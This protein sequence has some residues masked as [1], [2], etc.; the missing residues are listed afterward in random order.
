MNNLIHL[1]FALSLFFISNWFGKNSTRFGYYQ[2]SFMENE[3]KPIFNI[4]YRSFTPVIFISALSILLNKLDATNLL[5]NIYLVTVYY[6]AI[7]FFFIIITRREKLTSWKKQIMISSIS[8]GLSYLVYINFITKKNFPLPTEQEI[9]TALW[10]AVIGYIYKTLD[11]ISIQ[12][13]S[14]IRKKCYIESMHK[15][16]SFKYENTIEQLIK[17]KDEIFIEKEKALIYS[18]LIYENFNRHKLIR[19]LEKLFFWTGKVKTSG[20]MQV[21]SKKYLSDMDSLKIG[22]AILIDKYEQVFKKTFEDTEN[23]QHSFHVARRESI[24]S[25]NPDRKYIDEVEAIHTELKGIY[26]KSSDL[27]E[28]E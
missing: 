27:Y 3:E 7:R 23:E 13:S 25:Y 1:L 12:S 28:G 22:A 26:P 10:F 19:I 20:I 14:D 2:L 4:L 5:D 21:S 24:K 16:F 17:N 11:N 15:G 9:A 6:I 8:I 18:V